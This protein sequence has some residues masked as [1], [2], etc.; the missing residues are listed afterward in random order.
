MQTVSFAWN[1]KT[2]FLGKKGEIC[3][4][5][6]ILFSGKKKTNKKIIIIFPRK[7]DL[8][9]QANCLQWR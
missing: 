8:T 3:K 5:G 9:F 7:Q 2:C 6:Q 1:V 4:E